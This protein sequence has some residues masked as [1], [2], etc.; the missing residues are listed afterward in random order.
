MLFIR[1]LAYLSELLGARYSRAYTLLIS[2]YITVLDMLLEHF[3]VNVNHRDP[4]SSVS[5]LLG[6]RYSRAYMLLDF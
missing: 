2:V 6:A 1:Y 5:E 3:S 4:Q